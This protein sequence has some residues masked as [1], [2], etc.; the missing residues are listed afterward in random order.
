MPYD[1]RALFCGSLISSR[2]SGVYTIG[3]AGCRAAA[4]AITALLPVCICLRFPVVFPEADVHLLS[5]FVCLY[6]IPALGARL[7]S[8]H[9]FE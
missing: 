5:H 6:L 4:V 2:F 7:V 9:F 1:A 3:F 8:F